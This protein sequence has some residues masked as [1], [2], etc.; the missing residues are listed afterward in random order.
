MDPTDIEG[1]ALQLY[2]RTPTLTSIW[3][4]VS[5]VYVLD[6]GGELP[7]KIIKAGRN[8]TSD[9][10]VRREQ[11]ILS[12]LRAQGLAVPDI[13]FT[14]DDVAAPHPFTI[15]PRHATITLGQLFWEIEQ[16]TSL[17]L[18][19]ALGRWLAQM[20]TLP[21]TAVAGI[22]TPEQ[23]LQEDLKEYAF[24]QENLAAQGLLTP[25]YTAV[26][27]GAYHALHQPRHTLVHRDYNPSQVMMD[28]RDILYVVDWGSTMHGFAA[29]DLGLCMAYVKFFWQSAAHAAQVWAGYD[30]V[31]PLTP[32]DETRRALWERYTLLRLLASLPPEM[33]AERERIQNLLALPDDGRS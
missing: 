1:I 18:F 23:A 29:W 8:K 10:E 14:Q 13:E 20:Q 33:L 31:R 16:E 6:F 7:D 3:S 12:S 30:A 17:P 25:G 26:L 5:A 15:M 2:G 9:A 21:P 28:G 19:A 11:T 27:A 24:I 4:F 32:A 22:Y